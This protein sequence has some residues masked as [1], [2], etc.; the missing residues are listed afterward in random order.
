MLARNVTSENQGCAVALYLCVI[1]TVRPR[2]LPPFADLVFHF[3]DVSL[4]LTVA[5]TPTNQPSQ[6]IF[7]HPVTMKEVGTRKLTHSH[8]NLA[9]SNSSCRMTLSTGERVVLL[10]QERSMHLFKEP[11]LDQIW[12]VS[13]AS[14]D[15]K[16][17]AIIPVFDCAIAIDPVKHPDE[18]I[19]T[20]SSLCQVIH[21]NLR[22]LETRCLADHDSGIDYP[23]AICLL[24]HSKGIVVGSFLVDQRRLLPPFDE[25]TGKVPRRVATQTSGASAVGLRLDSGREVVAT[26]HSGN[27]CI[28]DP[29]SEIDLLEEKSGD[30]DGTETPWFFRIKDCAPWNDFYYYCGG[31]LDHFEVV[32]V[33]GTGFT[34]R[35]LSSLD[36]CAHIQ[37]RFP[38]LN[39][40][41]FF[42][43]VSADCLSFS[44]Q[45]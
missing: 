39:C 37:G 12:E 44:Q 8:F 10:S 9:L 43:A 11:S 21:C 22:T 3:L 28:Y 40:T 7:F 35:S 41:A 30:D 20:S 36:I 2:V 5:V 19:G 29:V 24:P 13:N 27:V 25:F 18:I 31:R 45:E 16:K 15:E 42:G 4:L 34:L 6:L 32:E 38:G 26:G 23:D 33:G 1:G 14:E 17:K